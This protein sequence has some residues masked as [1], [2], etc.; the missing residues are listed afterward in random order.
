MVQ[1]RFSVKRNRHFESLF[2]IGSGLLN[3]RASLPEGL[4]DDPQNLT[5][6][7]RPT[8]VT[9]E[10]FAQRK[11]CW[12]TFV[13]GFAEQHPL[14]N[15]QTINL[16]FPL[17]LIVAADGE[18]L[19][20]QR[21][22]VSRFWRWID[23][24][25][26]CLH[27][28]LR[29]HTSSGAEIDVG[30]HSYVHM[31]RREAV[32]QCLTVGVVQEGKSGA[33]GRGVRIEVTPF[34]DGDVRTNGFD[35]FQACR[36]SCS[37][38]S[39][40]MALEVTT[41]EERVAAVA[42]AVRG[43]VLGGGGDSNA[44]TTWSGTK[45]ARHVELTAAVRLRAGER[46][47]V[48]KVGAVVTSLDDKAP[49][50]RAEELACSTLSVGAPALFE[51]HRRTWE[52]IWRRADVEVRG[53]EAAALA[54]R[55]SV[56]HLLRAHPRHARAAICAKANGGDAYWGRIHWDNEIFIA[57]FF[58]Y[59]L[60]E[61]A[62]PL[63]EYRCRLLA[64]ARR[65]ARSLGYPGAMFPW[66]SGTAG[67]EQ[68]PS[69]QYADHEVHVSSD[70]VL[71]LWHYVCATGD[72]VFLHKHAAAVVFEVA[73]F[74]AARVDRL[75]GSR[76]AHILCV[77]GPD[78]YTHAADDNA[79]T[80]HLARVT[81]ALAAD[82]HGRA[83]TSGASTPTPAPTTTTTTSTTTADPKLAGVVRRLGI[84]NAEAR[85]WRKIAEEMFMPYDD[86]LGL[87][88]QSA[89]FERLAPLD[90]DA[91]W[92]DR[93]QPLGRFVAQER[94]Y[95]S[96]ALKQADALLL[97]QLFPDCFTREDMARAY[98]Y[99]EPC[100]THD[101][102]LSPTTHCILAALLGMAEKA[103]HYFE[104]VCRCDLAP[105]GAPAAAGIHAANAGGLWQC[106]VFG[107]LGLEPAYLGDE[108]NLAPRLPSHWT[109]CRIRVEWRGVPVT[110]DA[111]RDRIEVAP[112]GRLPVRVNG[113]RRWCAAG[114]TSTFPVERPTDAPASA[115]EH[116]EE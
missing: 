16:P 37:A 30:F 56:Y 113:V 58:I 70:V 110:I 81:L 12:G 5:Y 116:H 86:G 72:D 79:Y 18:R 4:G 94:L 51:Q 34:L 29:W 47:V 75:P 106:V 111:R 9:V 64:G 50:A 23:L 35:H 44:L 28:T 54:L 3:V 43:G 57:P 36:A 63:L 22:K 61:W 26:G 97:M 77:M 90:F 107:F 95:R 73:R 62:H 13:P 105:Q 49:R 87:L 39:G 60:P 112:E 69:S 53:D 71:G 21:S 80:N 101:S 2:T 31:T 109:G 7:R 46:L 92:R 74:W 38:R 103:L 100:T 10:R 68:C 82:L 66:E 27:R 24:R 84:T 8:N 59:A 19:D 55:F 48:D 52:A 96:R 99:Y 20:M 102:S 89:D 76:Y 17:G 115:S 114:K 98:R 67:D 11:S 85:R 1:R 40:T 15:E 88:L 6:T 65:R 45:G 42:S 104:Q 93:R 108:L 33:R 14:L 32:A 83:A 91:V 25:Y 78:E 41:L